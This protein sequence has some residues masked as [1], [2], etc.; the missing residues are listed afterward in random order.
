MEITYYVV[1]LETVNIEKEHPY[2]LVFK[3]YI[4]TF[5]G[6]KLYTFKYDGAISYTDSMM[7]EDIKK[8]IEFIFVDTYQDIYDELFQKKSKDDFRGELIQ[9]EL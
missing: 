6:N 8:D 4:P 5:G 9:L 2:T 1:N 7:P 3:G